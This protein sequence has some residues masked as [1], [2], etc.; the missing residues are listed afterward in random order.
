MHHP[1]CAGDMLDDK[2]AASLKKRGKGGRNR[3]AD[4]R[5]DPNLDPK[6]ASRI[7]SNRYSQQRYRGQR[8]GSRRI[9]L[10][11]SCSPWPC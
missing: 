9:E 2:F 10:R 5:L 4:A 8:G 11:M 3:A 7:M 1:P 6:K